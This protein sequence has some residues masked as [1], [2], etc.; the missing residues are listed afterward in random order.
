L[1]YFSVPVTYTVPNVDDNLKNPGEKVDSK[2]QKE[3][4]IQNPD[5]GTDLSTIKAKINLNNINDLENY[6]KI[7]VI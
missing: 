3:Q 1:L 2:N 4:E 6:E 7:K 5:D